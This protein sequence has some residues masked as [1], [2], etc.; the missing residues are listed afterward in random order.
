MNVGRS[1]VAWVLALGAAA[2]ACSA[3][4]EATTIGT[5]GD[6]ASSGASG[7]PSSPRNPGDGTPPALDTGGDPGTRGPAAAAAD[8]PA[9][10][11]DSLSGFESP[12]FSSFDPGAPSGEPSRGCQQA[13]RTFIPQIPTVF[14]LVDRSGSMF[15]ENPPGSGQNAWGALRQG[16]LQVISE[17]QSDVR[18]GF[19]AFS[20]QGAT[21]PDM[22]SAAAAL[23]NQPAI[24]ALYQSLERSQYKDTPTLG[25]LRA[26]SEQL[27]SD[28]VEGS[29]Y[30][31]FVTDGEPDYC[32]DGNALCPPDSV[33]GRLQRMAAGIDDDGVQNEPIQTLVF[34]I[35][36]PL[37]TI[38][39]EVLAAFA[40]AGAAEPVAP[41]V[42]NPS[43]V[44]D[45]CNGVPGWAADFATTGKALQRGATIGDYAVV[46]GNATVYRPDP[47]DR[48]ELVRQIRAALAGVK[49]CAFD[50]GGDG[51][52]VDVSR[53]DLGALA[54]VRLDGAEVPFDS[55]NGWRMLTGTTVQLEGAACERWRVPGETSIAFDFPCDVIVI[56]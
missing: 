25:A 26:V 20:G 6:T 37:S 29:K 12:D 9:P 55:A 35:D 40:N 56:R 52:Q 39:P 32:D 22:P 11:T 19:G 28:P 17:L 27:W 8:A 23:D 10:T 24:A 41:L 54:H 43:S 47:T 50:L 21:C 30:I 45:Q 2:L 7:A 14:I 44:F 38:S 4:G 33:V 16:V 53:P 46:G 31:L 1:R 42:A 51:V 15:D 18:F 49:S 34:G 3:D 36:S 48:A 13:A 5:P